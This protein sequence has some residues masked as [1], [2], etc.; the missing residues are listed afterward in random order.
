MTSTGRRAGR[1]RASP[2]RRSAS[3]T[4]PTSRTTSSGEAERT[5]TAGSVRAVAVATTPPVDRVL[6]L[7]HG[8]GRALRLGDD[9]APGHGYAGLHPPVEPVLLRQH[10]GGGEQ[11]VTGGRLRLR[12]GQHPGGGRRSRC[13]T[14]PGQERLVAQD[15][16]QQV[17]VGGDAVQ[18]R[19]AERVGQQAGGLLAGRAPRRSPSRASRRSASTTSLPV[20][21][22]ES[23]RMPGP[24]EQV[25]LAGRRPGT[26]TRLSTPL[27]GCQSADG[28]SA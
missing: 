4:P 16:D 21:N 24:V 1:V 17:A 23:S 3:D 6:V 18:S 7:A 22:P 10:D 19:P 9:V 15:G 27:C 14:S 20:S 5:C 8:E 28:S 2:R 13:S 11:Q 26:S 12:L 25:E